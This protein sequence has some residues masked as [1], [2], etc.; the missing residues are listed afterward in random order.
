[1]W[2]SLS[3]DMAAAAKQRH[4]TIAPYHC[5]YPSTLDN[6]IR[7]VRQ[8]ISALSRQDL[9]LRSC[10]EC[11]KLLQ[12]HRVPDSREHQSSG[13]PPRHCQRGFWKFWRK[14][15]GTGSED[16]IRLG[17]IRRGEDVNEAGGGTSTTD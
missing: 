5:E 17:G 11:W 4:T 6:D 14:S 13:V 12:W 16:P 2:V 9:L 8:A 3:L 15:R 10:R 7:A 1:M